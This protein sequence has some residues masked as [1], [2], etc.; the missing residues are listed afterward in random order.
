MN[1]GVLA[2]LHVAPFGPGA[3]FAPLKRPAYF[4]TAPSRSTSAQAFSAN[5]QLFSLALV[6]LEPITV[7]TYGLEVVTAAAGG[8]LARLGLA[9]ADEAGVPVEMVA[10]G[11]TVAIDTLG[12][13]NVRAGLELAPGI[14]YGVSLQTATSGS[15][16]SV[17][18]VPVWLPSRQ[19]SSLIGSSICGYGVTVPAGGAFATRWSP[20]TLT[21]QVQA[22]KF[23]VKISGAEVG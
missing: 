4:Y 11:D 5:V 7:E 3:G 15:G 17:E 9:R 6:T 1:K 20:R 14:Y 12:F 2:G 13:K 16:R 22:M 21:P 19:Q 18:A 23:N 10:D 8:S